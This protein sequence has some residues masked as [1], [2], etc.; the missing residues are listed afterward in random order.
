MLSIQ[1]IINIFRDTKAVQILF[2]LLSISILQVL[3]LFLAIFLTHI[4]GEYLIM[5]ILCSVS[6]I[7]MFF[8]VIRIKKLIS[9]VTINCNNG[10]FPERY[11]FETTGIFTAA[12][13]IFIPGFISG[14]I[15]FL[16][17]IP[18]LSFKTGKYISAKTYTDWHTVYEYMKI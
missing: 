4:F 5:A 16:L 18:L 13:M 8:S 12:I 2:F 7:G 17:L 3:D 15:G 11:F 1:F 6:L 14:I 9:I 10:I